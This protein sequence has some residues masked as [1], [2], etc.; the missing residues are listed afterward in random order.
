MIQIINRTGKFKAQLND[1]QKAALELAGEFCKGKMDK[2]VAVDTGFL[3]SRN[4]YK[5]VQNELYLEN[6]CYYAIYQEWGTY[7]MAAHP[8]MRPAAFNH[9]REIQEIMVMGFG[10]GME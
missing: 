3:K 8:F 7:K 1:N 5:I 2:Y 6:D 9:I 10:R 4:S